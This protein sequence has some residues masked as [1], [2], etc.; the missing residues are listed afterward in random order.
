MTVAA[1][2]DIA[3][4]VTS[5]PG[6]HPSAPESLPFAPSLDI[7]AFLLERERGN[8]L[9]YG[10]PELEAE[11]EPVEALGGISRQYLNHR[12]EAMFASDWVT[13][14][15]FVHQRE[16]R[17]V[18]RAHKVRGTFSR[19]H[20]L[21]EDLEVIPT[22]GHTSGATAYLWDSGEHR[23]LF[24]GDTIYLRGG[25]W[26]AAVLDSSDRA[27]YLESLELIRELDFDVLVP[28][29]ASGGDPYLATTDQAD[30]RRRIDRMIERVARGED[31]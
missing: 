28:W 14:P 11:A 19:R 30:A 5:V 27:A 26:V 18:E 17:S 20:L 15:L 25:E 12:H 8:L 10:V 7:R 21:D 1:N 29:A 16:R 31:H 22:P 3:G 23:L 6:L 2:R 4:M 13:A 9:I 24:T